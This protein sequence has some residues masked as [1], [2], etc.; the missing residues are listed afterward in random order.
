MGSLA[1]YV[2]KVVIKISSA[3]LQHVIDNHTI[4]GITNAGKSIFSS[5]VN[6]PDLLSQSSKYTRTLQPGGNYQRVVDAGKVIGTDR[7]TGK[8]TQIYTVITDSADNLV[9][10]FPGRP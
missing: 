4:T 6:I 7:T 9:T 2:G 1:K 3:R 10:A 8:S 5:N